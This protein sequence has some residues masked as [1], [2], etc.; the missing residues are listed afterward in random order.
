MVAKTKK[1]AGK[2]TKKVTELSAH[3][4]LAGLERSA[5]RRKMEMK[6]EDKDSAARALRKLM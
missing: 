4:T 6:G 3:P 2:A 1:E 5:N